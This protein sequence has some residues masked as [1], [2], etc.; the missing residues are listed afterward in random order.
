MYVNVMQ[1]YE[2]LWIITMMMFNLSGQEKKWNICG[3]GGKD[4]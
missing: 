2:F 1:K 4:Q 3:S